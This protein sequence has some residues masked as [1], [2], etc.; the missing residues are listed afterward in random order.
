MDSYRKEDI[1]EQNA[2]FVRVKDE[3]AKSGERLY[4]KKLDTEIFFDDIFEI[5]KTP[6]DVKW[7]LE[8]IC[9]CAE[10]GVM[11]WKQEMLKESS[12]KEELENFEACIMVDAEI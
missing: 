12:E 10:I 11:D 8:Q 2:W 9:Y 7:M 5:A 4:F 3:K 6:S 1:I